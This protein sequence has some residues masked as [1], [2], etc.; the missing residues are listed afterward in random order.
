MEAPPMS[1]GNTEQITAHTLLERV[2]DCEYPDV[3][4]AERGGE[5]TGKY[6]Y[7]N[8]SLHYSGQKKRGSSRPFEVFLADYNDESVELQF[9][10][11]TGKAEG[12]NGR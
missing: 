11:D 12:R 4:Y 5:R 8:N 3:L 6:W 10:T 7:D 2:R 1:S 9:D